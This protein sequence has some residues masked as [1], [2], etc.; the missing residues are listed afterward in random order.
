MECEGAIFNLFQLLNFFFL[1]LMLFLW[2]P[3]FWILEVTA[4]VDDAT[5]LR[6]TKIFE[7][8]K[9]FFTQSLK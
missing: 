3:V 6:K 8:V 7:C 1:L 2:Y 4:M 9:S 5:D